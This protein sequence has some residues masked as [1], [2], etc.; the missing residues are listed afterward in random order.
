MLEEKIERERLELAARRRVE[1]E[2]LRNHRQ[3]E[4]SKPPPPSLFFHSYIYI[5]RAGT[6]LCSFSFLIWRQNLKKTNIL[7]K[8]GKSVPVLLFSFKGQFKKCS[9]DECR[10]QGALQNVAKQLF[11][12]KRAFLVHFTWEWERPAVQF[13]LPEN[14]SFFQER[15]ENRRNRMDQTYQLQREESMKVSLVFCSRQRFG[16]QSCPL[17]EFLSNTSIGGCGL[18]KRLPTSDLAIC[19]VVR[20]LCWFWFTAPK[21]QCAQV[22]RLLSSWTGKFANTVMSQQYDLWPNALSASTCYGIRVLSAKFHTKFEVEQVDLSPF[23]GLDSVYTFLV[24]H[25]CVLLCCDK[26]F[27]QIVPRK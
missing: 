15:N 4:V 20:F 3:Q 16:S 19:V 6:K 24:Q 9:G 11:K 26:F 21:V 23:C 18:A 2:R 22:S 7:P 25:G 17:N 10:F 8:K 1:N 5:T 12:N 13:H 27:Q 14:L